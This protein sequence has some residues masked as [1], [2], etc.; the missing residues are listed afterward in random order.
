MIFKWLLVGA[1]MTPWV[2]GQTNAVNPFLTGDQQLE[3]ATAPADSGLLTKTGT[4]VLVLNT[5][6]QGSFRCNIPNLSFLLNMNCV[7]NP[8]NCR[9]SGTSTGT[10]INTS[11]SS[12]PITVTGQINF[13]ATQP[14]LPQAS[15]LVLNVTIVSTNAVF[16]VTISSTPIQPRDTRGRLAFGAEVGEPVSALTGEL[17]DFEPADL[18][19]GGPAQVRFRRYKGSLLAINGI[20]SALGANW[21]HNFEVRASVT[22]VQTGV[23]MFGG[24]VIW[25]LAKGTDWIP[26]FTNRLGYQLIN[27]ADGGFQFLDPAENL[28]YTFTSKG[29]LTAVTDRNGNTLT[30][31]QGTNGPTQ[32]SDGLGRTLTFTYQ[33]DGKLSQVKDQSG[34][35]VSFAYTNGI[36]TSVTDVAGK[37]TSHSIT[38]AGTLT[39]LIS[40]TIRPGGN[41]AFSQTYDATGR[42]ASQA[43]G[44]GNSSAIVYSSSPLGDASIRDPLG[45][46]TTV[47]HPNLRDL[48]RSVDSNGNAT[49]SA[50]DANDRPVSVVDRNGNTSTIAY[51]NPS[52][53]PASLT[54]PA[55]SQ[56]TLSYTASTARGFTF[57]DRTGTTYA[58]G[59]T[60]SFAYDANGNQVKFID[61]AGK[62]TTFTYDSRGQVLTRTNALGG[63]TTLTYNTDGTLATL[64]TPSGDITTY[65]YDA[66]KR[67]SQIKLPDGAT[68][69]FTYDAFDRVTQA[70]DER[71][72][73]TR[74]AYTDNG[75]LQSVTDPQGAVTSLTYDAAENVASLKT[76][77]GTTS[78]TYNAVNL[79]SSIA[80]PTGEVLSFGYDKLNQN[81]SIADRAGQVTSLTHDNEGAINSVTDGA[82]RIFKIA[83]DALGQATQLTAP[84]GASARQT[85]DKLGRLASLIDALGAVISIAY[86]VRGRISGLALPEGIQSSYRYDDLG[87]LN[88]FADP[89]GNIWNFT[90]DTQ[91]RLTSRKDPLGR[92]LSYAY[93]SRNRVA[94]IT[95]ALGNAKFTYDAAGN[96]V[97]KL[98]SD[99]TDLNYTYDDNNRLTGGTGV[100][101]ARDADGRIVNSNGLAV[102]RDASGRISS[103][104]YPPGKVTYSYNNRGQ[105]SQVLDWKGA[106]TTLTYDAS[107][108]RSTISRANGVV[109]QY[110]YDA[111]GRLSGITE[112]G[113]APAPGGRA[114]RDDVVGV[115]LSKVTYT[116]NAV[117]QVIEEDNS[118]QSPQIALGVQQF[119]Y[120][121]NQD[122]QATYDALGRRT[123]GN[124]SQVSYDLASNPRSLLLPGA[125]A[126]MTYNAFGDLTSINVGSSVTIITELEGLSEGGRPAVV[127]NGGN[128]TFHI[129]VFPGGEPLES[130]TSTGTRYF[131]FVDRNTS[132]VTDQN[133]SVTDTYRYEPRGGVLQHV[134]PSSLPFTLGGQNGVFSLPGDAIYAVP[135]RGPFDP[136]TDAYLVPHD[137]LSQGIDDFNSYLYSDGVIAQA[138][139]DVPFERSSLDN[140]AGHRSLPRGR[141]FAKLA[142][143]FL[144]LPKLADERYRYQALQNQALQT[145]IRRLFPRT[146]AIV[147]SPDTLTPATPTPDVVPR[148]RLFFFLRGARPNWVSPTRLTTPLFRGPGEPSINGRFIGNAPGSPL[149]DFPSL[150]FPQN[151]VIPPGTPTAT[152]NVKPNTELPRDAAVELLRAF[153]ILSSEFPFFALS[154]EEFVKP[155]VP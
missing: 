33:P 135:Q 26:V 108:R 100:T 21:M 44:R 134:G 131:H 138:I 150:S 132:M 139:D 101:L 105:L 91:G 10:Y 35:A 38:S 148:D 70:I 113:P 54:D 66:L 106:A 84:S 73:V 143:H 61:R 97:R 103:I 31:T 127:T 151:V 118:D 8:R 76:P 20:A 77:A 23:T 80:S 48:T 119:A 32:V 82:G 60:E 11:G 121:A 40:K 59:T 3:V 128:A 13:S 14:N 114:Q 122:V 115:T 74:A 130:I 64:K 34:R 102:G 125:S 69:S 133:G 110:S 99:G 120:A 15:Q 136:I 43:D 67:V 96:L 50:Y 72:K 25:F 63:V 147:N 46:V 152:P 88:S 57:Y 109:T 90:Y 153:A 2:F 5:N 79:P 94:T 22:V 47:S 107:G 144:V 126:S 117:G 58:N 71:S 141:P 112:T 28:I 12:L 55:G 62:A 124:L 98:Y 9:S 111:D 29:V 137:V 17:Y 129:F 142:P 87:N 52:G 24:E 16:P 42:V 93:D 104:M 123:V 6:D 36:L 27:T 145:E 56:T 75:K 19:L 41:T 30:V 49:V 140:F 86:D 51:H 39:G 18:S 92:V 155:F 45:N 65:T 85:F 154:S 78:V 89:D 146:D 1:L 53:Y 68:Q 81:T 4:G 7:N 37:V 149:S 95:H 116:Y 83:R